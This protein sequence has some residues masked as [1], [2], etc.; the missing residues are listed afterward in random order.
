MLRFVRRRFTDILITV[1]DARRNKVIKVTAALSLLLMI[2]FTLL[3]SFSEPI[4]QA[5]L[6]KLSPEERELRQFDMVYMRWALPGV[7]AFLWGFMLGVVA[8]VSWVVERR[9]IRK[10]ADFRG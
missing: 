7:L 1:T 5:E 6:S 9:R 4:V 8:I 3:V 2:L 10:A